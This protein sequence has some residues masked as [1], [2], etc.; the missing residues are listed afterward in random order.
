[1]KKKL[2]KSFLL[3]GVLS[4]LLLSACTE[5]ELNAT[6]SPE[7]GAE[8]NDTKVESVSLTEEEKPVSDEYY[9][10]LASIITDSIEYSTKLSQHNIDLFP[11]NVMDESQKEPYNATLDEFAVYLKGL[12]EIPDN[13][14]EFKLDKLVTELVYHGESRIEYTRQFL[15]TN[16]FM[17]RDMAKE[18]Y[19]N[20]EDSMNTLLDELEALQLFA[21]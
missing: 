3:V 10:M 7:A 4:V 16:D 9:L 13:D 19:Q 20:W 5:E 15:K 6:L 17:Y 21:E 14:V 18:E 12:N 1:M 8:G 11:N 2:P